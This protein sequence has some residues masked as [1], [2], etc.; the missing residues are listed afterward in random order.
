MIILSLAT[1]I[2]Q[3]RQ[4]ERLPTEWVEDAFSSGL[5][6]AVLLVVE[7]STVAVGVTV[8]LRDIAKSL[9]RFG[10]A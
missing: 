4:G 3:T 2:Y 5:V 6:F 1:G 7:P 8:V 10:T 9:Q